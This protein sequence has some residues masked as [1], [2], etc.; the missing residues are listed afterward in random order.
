MA[1]TV[2]LHVGIIVIVVI[3]VLIVLTEFPSTPVLS[4]NK[5]L[6]CTSAGRQ[7]RIRIAAS[8]YIYI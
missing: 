2:I 7:G 1:A 4:E 6:K 8:I 3:I 5:V